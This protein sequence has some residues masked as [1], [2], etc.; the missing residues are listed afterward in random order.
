MHSNFDSS[1]P[2]LQLSIFQLLHIINLQSNL[3]PY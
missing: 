1:N 2:T 3:N